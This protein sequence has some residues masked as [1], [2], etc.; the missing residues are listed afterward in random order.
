MTKA[1]VRTDGPTQP[2]SYSEER[3]R[4]LGP[5]NVGSRPPFGRLL[6]RL[7]PGRLILA[8]QQRG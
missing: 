5:C 8:S 6:D 1:V 4:L 3:N 2:G 7:V